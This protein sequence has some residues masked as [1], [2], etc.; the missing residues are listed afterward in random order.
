MVAAEYIYGDKI[1]EFFKH[2]EAE[3][4]QL[5]EQKASRYN[6]S[7]EGLYF[8]E[9]AANIDWV[10]NKPLNAALLELQEEWRKGYTLIS[11]RYDPL[12]FKA[13]LRKPE[14][15]IKS[16]LRTLED[17][18]RTEY[19][20]ARYERNTVET[21]RQVEITLSI[22]RRKEEAKAAA[23]LAAALAALQEDEE[24]ALADLRRAYAEPA[25]GQ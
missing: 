5:L 21:T 6:S 8:K 18:V 20:K 23:G 9:P 14:K 17:Q 13:Q 25:T 15:V 24:A 12:D 7:S 11:S 4:N 2:D 1:I 10:R 16:E 19:S 22:K 3:L